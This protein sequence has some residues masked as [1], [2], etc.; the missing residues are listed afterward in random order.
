MS[1][2][3][4]VNDI[5]QKRLATRVG[6]ESLSPRLVEYV[7]MQVMKEVE[8]AVNRALFFGTMVQL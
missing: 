5:M 3:E 8:T 2:W 1:N 6:K 7:Q 4:S